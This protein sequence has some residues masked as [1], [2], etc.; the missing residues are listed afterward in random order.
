MGAACNN[1]CCFCNAHEKKYHKDAEH[2]MRLLIAGRREQRGN[3]LF[4]GLE[5][6]IHPGFIGLISCAKKAGYTNI[7]VDTNARMFSYRKFTKQAQRAGLTQARI[8]VPHFSAEGYADITSVSRGF[9][10]CVRGIR[11]LA[12]SASVRII[13]RIPICSKNQGSLRS[14]TEFC[15]AV[16]IREV[17]FFSPGNHL[18]RDEDYHPAIVFEQLR[19]SEE[20]AVAH[21]MHCDTARVDR[22]NP[23]EGDL[24]EQTAPCF[25]P[26]FYVGRRRHPEILE[27]VLRPTFAC[28]QIC[29]FCWINPSHEKPAVKDMEQEIAHVIKRQIPKLAFSGG[30]PT[31]VPRLPEYIAMAKNG[32]VRQVEIHTNAMRFTHEQLCRDIRDAGLDLA[33]CT[34]LAHYAKA[35]DA[36]T[37]TEGSFR[38][39]VAGIINLMTHS[40]RVVVHFVIMGQN[41]KLLPE[42]VRFVDSTFTYGQLRLPITFSYVAPRDEKAMRDGIVPRFSEAV[43]YLHEAIS[44]CSSLK[45]PFCAGEGLKGI[46][47]CVIPY[48][49]KYVRQLLPPSCNRYGTAFV[50]KREC[51]Q[52]MYDSACFGVRRHYAEFYGL[53]EIIPVSDPGATRDH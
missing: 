1:S 51:G 29:T 19:L 6:T 21:S 22:S 34:L 27:A 16:R 11:N 7:A 32:G 31:L 46:P 41:Y 38:K 2:I 13:A 17:Q 47:Q 10:E 4:T 3:V 23:H 25:Y 5:P 20:F 40:I 9:E 43:P 33:Y 44:L 36:I 18:Y 50:K 53:D 26:T 8:L 14:I 48:R 30:E 37:R 12:D 42:F 52:C 35:S 28:N 24:H 45:I 49:D 39:T 15:H